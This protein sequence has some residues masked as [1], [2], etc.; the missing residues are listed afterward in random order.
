MRKGRPLA[1]LTFC[2]A[3][4]F[5]VITLVSASSAGVA[6]GV[7]RFRENVVSYSSSGTQAGAVE[8]WRTQVLLPHKAQTVGTGVLA[9]IRVDDNTTI[10]ECNGTYI[11][12]RGRI[13]VAGQIINRAA[14][15]LSIIGGSGIYVPAGGV[16]AVQPGGLVTF[17]LS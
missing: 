8:T 10:R 6:P 7:A 15:Q 2:A 3:L 9:C 11:L 16:M 5:A 12:P 1:V 17:F 4:T 14:Y 13:Q